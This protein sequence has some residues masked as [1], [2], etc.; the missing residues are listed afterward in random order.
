MWSTCHACAE[1]YMCAN[2]VS[3]L[4]NV[5]V[6]ERYRLRV[7]QLLPPEEW[8][9]PIVTDQ[10]QSRCG[11]FRIIHAEAVIWGLN[12]LLL[13]EDI[14]LLSRS[15]SSNSRCFAWPLTCVL[16]YSEKF[17]SIRRVPSSSSASCLSSD[18]CVKLLKISRYFSSFLL[19]YSK[20]AKG[21]S[22]LG[23]R[24]IGGLSFKAITIPPLVTRKSTHREFPSMCNLS[25]YLHFSFPHSLMC[26]VRNS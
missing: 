6:L 18:L 2:H 13:V 7:N 24:R 3:V 11:E 25:S 21:S 12:A 1:H 22:Q 16:L 8:R 10:E 9:S 15:L 23:S 20:A 5:T 4:L 14:F 26:L 17:A 19:A